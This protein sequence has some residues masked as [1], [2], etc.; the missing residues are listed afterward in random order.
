MLVLIPLGVV[1]LIGVV[2]LAI[3]QKSSLR[4]RLTALGALALMV[5]TVIICLLLV[6]GVIKTA[7]TTVQL[8]PD[9]ELTGAPP[10]PGPNVTM[11]IL[12]IVFLI[13]VFVLVL[14]LS[15]KQRKTEKDK[16]EW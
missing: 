16:N 12:L 11:M 7:A 8:P 9:A 1:T 13:A 10:V 15:L 3:S 2:Y 5:I 6:F 14:V 4:V